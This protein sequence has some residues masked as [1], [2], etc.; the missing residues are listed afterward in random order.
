MGVNYF[1][2]DDRDVKFVLFEQL[3]MKQL[4]GYEP[5]ADYFRG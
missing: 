3:D 1:K 2:R 4:L 5:F